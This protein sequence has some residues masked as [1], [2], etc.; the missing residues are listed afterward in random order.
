MRAAYV[1]RQIGIDR[2]VLEVLGGG[3][4]INERRRDDLLY[5]LLDAAIGVAREH[6]IA[7]ARLR[8]R[9]HRVADP[10]RR[11]VRHGVGK[12]PEQIPPRDDLTEQRL[13]AA[14]LVRARRLERL[15]DHTDQE[16]EL[17]REAGAALELIALQEARLREEDLELLKIAMKQH[18]LPRDQDLVEN[19][20]RVVF[21]E[22]RGQRIVERRAHDTCRHLVRRPAEQL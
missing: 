8:I 2:R 18:V 16:V 11:I 10:W 1:A 19:E 21:V 20:N 15:G 22:A 13:V 6:A 12:R 4:K 14:E 7:R 5:D 17:D 9:Q 3:W